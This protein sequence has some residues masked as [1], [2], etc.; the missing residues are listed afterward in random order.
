MILYRIDYDDGTQLRCQFEPHAE[1]AI[2]MK[3]AL[4]QEGCAILAGPVPIDVPL[5]PVQLCA[6][7]NA[8]GG[9]P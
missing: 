2:A 1:G 3:I 9:R 8:G 6:W 5:V 7:L 4:E